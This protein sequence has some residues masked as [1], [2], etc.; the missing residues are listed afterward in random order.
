MYDILLIWWWA[1]SLFFCANADK[2]IKKAIIEKTTNLWTKLLMAGGW[3]CNY[4]NLNANAET[5][6]GQNT[7]ML[8]S[9]FHKFW[10][11]E[12]VQWLEK[13]GIKSEEE[14]NGRMFPL[15]RKSKDLLGLFVVDSMKNNTDIFLDS[16]VISV[17]KVWKDGFFTSF[18]MTEIELCQNKMTD[19]KKTESCHTEWNEV[20]SKQAISLEEDYFLIKTAD[21]EFKTKKLIIAT[22][23]KSFPNTGTTGFAYQIAK[24]FGLKTIKP[25]PALCGLE[26][27]QDF[28]PLSGSTA[29]A[30]INIY[31]K[32]KLV[33]QKEWW[34][35]FTHRWISGP[36]VF[37]IS[38]FLWNI[39]N[40]KNYNLSDFSLDIQFLETTKRI[41][42]YLQTEQIQTT[43]TKIRDRNEAKVTGGWISMD[44][45]NPDF[46]SKKIPWLYFLGECLDCTGL[47]W[48][49]NLQR[50]WTSA[51]VCSEK[52]LL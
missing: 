13:R 25:Y 22:W 14:D 10:P 26:T 42:V 47:T 33:E 21:K 3:R 20:S 29:K 36:V 5:Y 4:T 23:G 45:I 16:E 49:Y 8:K 34:I 51:F 19:V 18:R 11:N 52:I 48:W 44:E 32:E 15:S 40:Q 50:C 38:L 39:I 6:L 24:Q 7:K 12:M 1:S 46:Q 35:L 17:E 27:S 30:K 2:N 31:H 28:S 43:I 37:N 9:L 41:R